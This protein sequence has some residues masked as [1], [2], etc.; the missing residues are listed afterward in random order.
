MAFVRAADA[1]LARLKS[2]SFYRTRISR[3]LW[4]VTSNDSVKITKCITS[5]P[6]LATCT[7]DRI[8]DI[9]QMPPIE[10]ANIPLNALGEPT[11]ASL[12]LN[13]YWPS[14]W[15]QA[16]LEFLHV[17]LNLPWWAAIATTTVVIRLC[18]IPFVINQ[19][20]K[21]ASYTNVMPQIHALQ[22]RMTRARVASD[23]IEM[24]KVSQEMQQLMKNNDV[25]LLNSM[26][27]ALIQVPIFL[28]VFAGLR[29]MAQ[30]PVESLQTGG[31][32]WFADLTVCDPFYVLP[33]YSM[34]SIFLMFEFGADV[35]S[36]GLTTGVRLAMRI[37]PVVGFFMIMHMPS[38]LL[39]Y[40]SISNTISISQALILR[41]KPVRT[42]L[43]FP[44][45]VNPPPQLG[46]KKGF[47]EGFK[48]SM[49]NSRLL[50]ELEA[51]ER[52]DAE[53]WQKAGMGPIPKTFAYDIRTRT[54]K[55]VVTVRGTSVPEKDQS[56][57]VKTSV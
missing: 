13:S 3:L 53:R 55:P 19:R 46:R 51:R 35:S 39:W 25:N 14:G 40:W 47:V 33:L 28:S 22:N 9:P 20:R 57:T 23:Y 45:K 43:K 2:A 34:S 49:N 1:L 16:A 52:M 27:L 5:F 17:D 31:L 41:T 11:F 12:G 54:K 24:M 56:Q 36:Q 6:L 15:Y 26:G 4:T 30:L 32:G 44:E 18:L 8:P 29:G 38:A 10:D 42:Y 48:E 7:S 21:L 50:A 37:F